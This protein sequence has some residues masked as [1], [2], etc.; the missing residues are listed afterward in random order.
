VLKKCYFY[1]VAAMLVL[2]FAQTATA[3]YSI[4]PKMK[5]W[6]EARFGMFIHFGTYSYLGHGEWAYF[7]EKK[8]TKESYQSQVSSKFNP[9]DFDGGKIARLAKKTGMKYIVITAKHHEGFS[10]WDTQVA[11]FKDASQKKPYDL[12]GFTQFT[13]RDVLQELKDS[14]EAQGIK[15]C[16][17]YSIMDW[18]HSSQNVNRGSYFSDMVSLSAR[19]AYIADMKL[20]IKELITKYKPAVMWF[21]GDWTKRSGSPT[22]GKW[23]TKADGADLYNYVTGLDPTIVV[24]ERVCRSFGLGDFECPERT[25]PNKPAS[26]QWETCQTMNKSWGYNSS[27]NNYKSV[28]AMVQELV[29]VVS[30]DGNYLLNIGPKGDG[31]VPAKTTELLES[32]GE[33]MAVYGESLY[34]ATRSPFKSEPSW[35]FCTKKQGK[36][37]LHVCKWPT[38]GTLKVPS[39]PD[40]VKN[41]YLMNDKTNKLTFSESNGE[42]S[43]AIPKNK[44]NPHVSV[45]VMDN[46]EVTETSID[47][48]KVILSGEKIST[49]SLCS[50]SVGNGILTIKQS[51]ISPLALTIY[52][53]NGQLVVNQKIRSKK[54]VQDISHLL[55]GVYLVKVS[56]GDKVVTQKFIKK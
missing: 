29:K 54:H 17:Y 26:R 27:D 5:W 42:Y 6:Y 55:T 34:G 20:Q 39:P 33:W 3:Q 10:M 13:S 50:G 15:F 25:V 48:H 47:F 46:G 18:L 16:L 21:D 14:C 38:N 49:I 45:I 9:V 40:P 53:I 32:I 28:T 31:T 7:L 4:P 23:W 56:G 35:G 8:W 41:V 2:M 1:L 36:T 22:L 51:G 24:N 12:P 52:T 44:P 11:S 37:Y 30:R 19:T 43:I